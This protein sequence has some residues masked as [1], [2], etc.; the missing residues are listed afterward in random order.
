MSDDSMGFRT[1]LR[2]SVAFFLIFFCGFAAGY[3]YLDS[4]ATGRTITIEDKSADCAMLFEKVSENGASGQN[5]VEGAGTVL[6]ASD[7]GLESAQAVP[8]GQFAASKNS[9]LYHT[10][11]CQYVKRIKPENLVWFGSEKEAQQGRT[12]HSCVK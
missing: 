11:D 6:S 4:K 10:R 5:G 2:L 12:P 8:Q 1:K 9:T 7:S 3:S